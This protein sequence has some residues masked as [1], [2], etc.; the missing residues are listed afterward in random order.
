MQ[1]EPDQESRLAGIAAVQF[2]TGHRKESDLALEQLTQMA[3]GDWASGIA[4]VHAI[5]NEPDA[6]FTW[7]DR[8]Y[9]Q[10]DEDLYII[11][12][13]PLLRNVAHDPRYDAFLRKLNLQE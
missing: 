10:K 11:R 9:T 1:Q 12:G 3:K 5:R 13:N 2:V 8:A 4:L 6:T 7:L